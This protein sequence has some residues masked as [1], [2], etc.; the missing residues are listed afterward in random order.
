M[1]SEDGLV[2]SSSVPTVLTNKAEFTK[3]PPLADEAPNIIAVVSLQR[4]SVLLRSL[5]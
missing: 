5:C 4:L 2:Y 3:I 1:V